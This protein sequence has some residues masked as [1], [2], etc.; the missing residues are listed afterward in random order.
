[1]PDGSNG[2]DATELQ[3]Y[4]DRLDSEDDALLSL[5]G[6]YMGD[7]QG[8][9]ARI[10]EI[11]G[12][13]REAG[14]SMVAFR[15]VLSKHRSERRIERKIAELEGDDAE[16]YEMMVEALAGLADTPLG[17][18]ALDRKRRR[19]RREGN[20]DSLNRRVTPAHVLAGV[21]SGRPPAATG[22]LSGTRSCPVGKRRVAAH[23]A[24]HGTAR[25][26][27]RP[28]PLPGRRSSLRLLP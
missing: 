14:H 1:M 4:L 27:A 3:G 7:C 19:G 26:A 20:L 12:E 17:E 9:R 24:R 11:M 8:P 25:F 18:A 21:L 13:V 16:T 2:F 28:V 22:P 6:T 23:H 15:T 5:K 10:K